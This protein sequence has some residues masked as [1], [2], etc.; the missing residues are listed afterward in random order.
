M[1]SNT[2]SNEVLGAFDKWEARSGSGSASKVGRSET[3]V[4]TAPSLG[5]IM[6]ANTRQADAENL[7]PPCVGTRVES[8]LAV[9]LVASRYMAF[10]A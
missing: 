8:S 7:I 9:K 4:E 3:G 5:P 6:Q 1:L 2:E 10:T